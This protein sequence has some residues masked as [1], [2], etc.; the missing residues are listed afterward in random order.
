MDARVSSGAF[1]FDQ[2]RLDRSAGGL[3][4]RTPNGQLEPVTLGSRAIDVLCAL[5]GRSGHLISKDEIMT[6]VWPDTMVDEANLAVQISALRRVLDQGR[7]EGSCIQTV[8]GRGYRFISAVSRVDEA[9]S[10]AGGQVQSGHLSLARGRSIKVAIAGVVA[11]TGL[12]TAGAW[13]TLQSSIRPGTPTATQPPQA[14]DRRMSVAIFPFVNSSGDAAQDSLAAEITRHLTERITRGREGPV[15][16]G[17]TASMSLGGLSDLNA[18]GREHNVHFALAGDARWQDGHLV[19]SA[20]LYDTA[21][22]RAVWGQQVDVPDGPGALTTIGQ[23]IYENWW[24]TST[25]MEAWHAAHDHPYNLDKRDLLMMA[26]TTPLSAPTK[27]NYLERM[28]FIDRALTLDPN[29]FLGL[30]RRARLHAQFVMLGYS[31]DPATDLAIATEAA[32][33]ALAIDPNSLNSLRVKA[34]VLRARGDWTTAEALQRRVLTL[35]PTEANRHDELGECLMAEG[36]HQEAL[37]SY[38]TARKYAGGGDQVWWYDTNIAMAYLALGQLAEAIATAQLA[39]GELP[40][41][42]GRSGERPRLVLIAATSL[43]GN[44]EAARADLQKFL[45]TPRSWHSIAEVLK[46]SPFAANPRLLDGLHRAGM[47]AE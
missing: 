12:L 5:I 6:A 9:V 25:D 34:S 10:E 40:P 26:L 14:P 31:S 18:V 8:A 20:A 38:H 33:H 28:S 7:H 15:I 11:L 41:D 3:F 39:I 30:E 35:Q 17:P 4:R 2:F 24:Q 22:G 47:P 13:L 21:E 1:L 29:F 46:W 27:A 36:R 16:A 23:V 43:S 32:D 19:V 42:T 45:A 37:A 44:E